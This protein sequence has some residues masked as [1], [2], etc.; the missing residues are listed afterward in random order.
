MSA[1]ALHLAGVA[2]AV[3]G[4]RP[5]QFFVDRRADLSV[6]NWWQRT[7]YTV[8]CRKLKGFLRVP[9]AP[10][11]Y[12]GIFPTF[13]Q[14]DGA[15]ESADDQIHVLPSG[16]AFSGDTVE[17]DIVCRPRDRRDEKRYLALRDRYGDE[18]EYDEL[19]ARARLAER[20]ENLTRGVRAAL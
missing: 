14:A 20:I 13:A 15:C 18:Y 8:E 10:P 2:A 4:V 11:L 9:P 19:E 1:E 12:R 16:W 6:L 7:R 5:V 3:D 17:P